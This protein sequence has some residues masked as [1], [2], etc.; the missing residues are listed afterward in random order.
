MLS[1]LPIKISGDTGKEHYTHKNHHSIDFIRVRLV[2]WLSA[3][4]ITR[5]GTLQRNR[6][7]IPTKIKKVET[8]DLLSSEIY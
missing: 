6:K 1:Q 7:G 4:T 3:K 5:T 2:E 8:R